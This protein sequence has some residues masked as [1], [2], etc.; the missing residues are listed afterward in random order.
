MHPSNYRVAEVRLLRDAGR[1]GEVHGVQARAKELLAPGRVS[2]GSCD[3]TEQAYLKALMDEIFTRDRFIA[4]V[5]WEE[6]D[7]PRMDAYNFSG[8]HDYI[9]VFSKSDL[10]RVNRLG[11]GEAQPASGG[12][13]GCCSGIGTE[14]SDSGATYSV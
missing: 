13:I 6:S 14:R 1:V 10:F 4:T 9:V 7:S 11:Q 3:D 8:R 5:I 2:V 12:I